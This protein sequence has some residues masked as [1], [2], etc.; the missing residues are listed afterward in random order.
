MLGYDRVYNLGFLRFMWSFHSCDFY[1]L[2]ANQNVCS[3]MVL[4]KYLILQK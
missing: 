4:K 3:K 2:A 1:C